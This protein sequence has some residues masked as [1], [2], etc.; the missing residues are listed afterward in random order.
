VFVARKIMKVIAKTVSGI[1]TAHNYIMKHSKPLV[2]KFYVGIMTGVMMFVPFVVPSLKSLLLNVGFGAPT[3][4]GLFVSTVI[5]AGFA[6]NLFDGM[7]EEYGTL[8]DDKHGATQDQ[9]PKITVLDDDTAWQ[10]ELANNDMN[11]GK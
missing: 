4:L 3:G 8:Y 10:R 2:K 1:A 5:A 9:S 7:V 11:D 6:K